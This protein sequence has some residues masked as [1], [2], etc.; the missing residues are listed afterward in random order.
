MLEIAGGI[1]LAGLIYLAVC[2]IFGAIVG[3]FSKPF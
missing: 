3:F 2:A 1:L